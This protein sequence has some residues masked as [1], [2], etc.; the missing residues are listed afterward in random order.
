MTRGGWLILAVIVGFN[1]YLENILGHGLAKRLHGRTN[2][3]L[4]LHSAELVLLGRIYF[5]A[6]DA[7]GLDT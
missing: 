1:F 6:V 7:S 2:L 5:I 3:L 4:A